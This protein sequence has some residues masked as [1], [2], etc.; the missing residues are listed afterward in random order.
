MD[1]FPDKI[2]LKLDIPCYTGSVQRLYDVPGHPELIISETTSGGSVFDVGTIFSIEGS[3]TG[4]AGFRHFVFQKLQDPLEWQHL[5]GVLSGSAIMKRDDSGMIETTLSMFKK[6]GALTHHVGMLDRNTGEVFSKRFPPELSNLTLIKKYNVHK[7]E[8]RRIMGWHF[9]DYKKYHF[10]DRFVIPLEYIVRLGITSGSSILRKYN[11][12][13]DDGKSAY[14][15]ELGLDNPLRP[16]TGFDAPIVD[17]TT[18]YEPEDRNISRQE[19]SLVSSLDGETFA[20]SMVMAILGAFMLREI[21]SGMGL[22]LWDLKWELAKDGK[23]LVFVDTIDTDSVRVTRNIVDND[24]SFFVHFNK[25]A[26]RDYYKI[27]HPAW[28][29]A[30][31]EAKKEAARTGKPFT[32]VLSEGQGRGVYPSNPQIDEAFLDIQKEK[33]NLIRRYIQGRDLYRDM[34]EETG[35]IAKS[36]LDYYLR[37]DKREQYKEL[38]AT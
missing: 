31:S 34:T 13:S 28:F 14:L 12:L 10:E 1:G 8:L 27:M 3:D 5:S 36:E 38:N 23:D 35:E 29:N 2:D 22:H 15:N 32:D 4:R 18:K 11:T 7:P 6:S 19:A 37:S 21:F 16:W 26:I 30:V 20:R 33:F 17:L 25:Q 9:Y 24:T